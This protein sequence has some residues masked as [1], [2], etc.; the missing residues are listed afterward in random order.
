MK[1][2]RR[3][4]A[5]IAVGLVPFAA[6]A[7]QNRFS[8]DV[9]DVDILDV[10]RLIGAETGTNIVADG[11]V[12]HERVTLRLRDVTLDD[13]L[14][15]VT[16][17]YDLQAHRDGSIVMLGAATS[18]NRRYSTDDGPYGTRTVVLALRYATPEEVAKVLQDALPQGTLVVADRRTSAVIVSGSG[19]TIDRARTLLVAL[20]G[21]P[22][23]RGSSGSTTVIPLRFLR[24][25]D[26]VKALKGLVPETGLI[27]DDRQNAVVVAAMPDVVVAARAL[28]ASLDVASRQVTFEVRVA[29]VTPTNDTSNVGLIF[30]GVSVQG[31]PTVGAA[32]TTFVRGSI[33]VN[34][35]LNALV[36]NGH[37][38]ILSQPRLTTL[39]NKEADMLVGASYPVVYF[40]ARTGTQQVQFVDI[41]V[42]LRLTPTIGDDGTITAELHPEYSQITGF[43]QGF[44]IIGSRKVNATLRVRDGETIVLAGLLS[45]FTTDTVQKIPGLGDIPVF[46]G[47]FRN[48]SAQ[49]QRDEIVFLITPH[50]IAAPK[51]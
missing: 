29:D 42:K 21:T 19:A 7:A 36:E 15:T 10:L 33:A 28:L 35:T 40:D 39:N 16:R 24:P 32:S 1:F 51:G 8:I 5:A 30:G 50:I 3:I 47:F 44:P 9:R 27:A 37:A 18:M 26:A 13:A 31:E 6:A 4:M 49:H 45:D 34:A 20:D 11:S 43:Q 41:G 48:R 17:A 12:K 46:G 2:V 23:A 25:S 22:Q 38:S 14:G